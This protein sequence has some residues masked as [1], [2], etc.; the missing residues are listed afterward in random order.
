ME[1]LKTVIVDDEEP[2]RSVVQQ[3]LKD[4][5]KVSVEAIFGAPSKA[6][7]Y[8]N[9]YSAD[10]LILDIQMPGMNGFEL[11]EQ[12]ETIPQVIF[13]TAYDAYALQAFEVNA[14][15]YLLKPYTRKRFNAALQRIFEKQ[16]SRE[17]ELDRIQ[18]LIKQYK[19]PHS[20]PDRLFVRVGV[21]IIPIKVKD[22]IW[23][24]ADGDYSKIYTEENSHLCSTGLGSLEEKL[25]PDLFQR[26]HR[27]YILAINKL[28]NLESDGGGGFTAKMSDGSKV[29]VSRSKAE[30]IKKL[31]V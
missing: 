30:Q 9:H 13:S 10:L 23:V 25:D 5:E 14:V 28:Q 18:S 2:G 26:C 8:L 20:Y 15:D 1:V 7:D 17:Q 11:L 22:I 3:Y 6:I 4:Q 27:S 29:K 31:I 24:E 19:T 16:E 12:L 21:R